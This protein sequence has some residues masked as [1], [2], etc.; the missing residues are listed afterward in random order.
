MNDASG[1]KVMIL[2][3]EYQINC[4]EEEREGLLTAAHYLDSKMREMRSRSHNIGVD[5]LAVIT[6]L[7]I[8]YEMVSLRPVQS[9]LE[10][11]REKLVELNQNVDTALAEK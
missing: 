7:N 4:P 1:V 6:A 10:Q 5:K 9:S 11:L 8:A 3:R 2:D